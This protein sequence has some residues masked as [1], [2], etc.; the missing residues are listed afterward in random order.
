MIS[1]DTTSQESP[2]LVV[3]YDEKSRAAMAASSA[4][5][6]TRAVPCATF[7]EAQELALSGF[8][9]G[10]LVDLATMIKAKDVEKVI[11]HT[12]TG[13]YP[14]LR[15]KAMGSM[16][17]PMIMAGDAK[18][19]K[20]LGDF[21]T[22]TCAAFPPRRLRNNKRKDICIPT[23]IE[24]GRGFTLN[25]SW[26]GVFIVDVNPERFRV[27]QE[28]EVRFLA[29]SDLEFTVPLAVVR[30]QP[31]GERRTPGIGLQFKLVD[32]E[33]EIYLSTILRID[34]I[35]DRDRLGT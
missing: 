35:T 6:G 12:L 13:I 7:Q 14:T 32:H 34:R 17:I 4:P 10:I 5:F 2:V 22:K 18:Q 30:V 21:F 11:A 1:P 25:I 9:R 29:G 15:V 33:L 27:G 3:A 31:W 26:S 16:L 8:F 23:Y 20:S 28:I 24:E 19:D